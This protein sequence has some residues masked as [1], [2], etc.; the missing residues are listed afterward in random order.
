MG[1]QS[2]ETVKCS[3]SD[4]WMVKNASDND[5]IVWCGAE[6]EAGTD[7]RVAYYG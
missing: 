2:G 1:E 5:Q 4:G 7:Q 6:I 3:S